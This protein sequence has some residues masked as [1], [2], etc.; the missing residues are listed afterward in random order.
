MTGYLLAYG[1]CFACGQVTGFN[2]DRVPSVRMRRDV[3]GRWVDDADAPA[4][5]LCR[6]CVEAANPLRV[7]QGLAPI[8]IYPDSYGP[9][10]GL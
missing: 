7:A 8:T 4:L 10:V 1:P 5:P 9:S 2:P 6:S 3:D